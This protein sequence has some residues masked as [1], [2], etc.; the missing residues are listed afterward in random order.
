MRT[1]LNYFEKRNIIDLKWDDQ[2]CLETCIAT[3]TEITDLIWH[4]VE[5]KW[6]ELFEYD[7][8][9]RRIIQGSIG[10]SAIITPAIK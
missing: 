6:P 5:K 9:K 3:I 10:F 7:I 1:L 8:D 2:N 4:E